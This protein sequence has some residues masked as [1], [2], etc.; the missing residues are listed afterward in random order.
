MRSESC[1]QIAECTEALIYVLVLYSFCNKAYTLYDVQFPPFSKLVAGIA[2]GTAILHSCI[3]PLYP[4]RT[5]SWGTHTHI[6]P[7]VSSLLRVPF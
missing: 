2:S 7:V 3:F 4:H 6:T 5:L 1:V